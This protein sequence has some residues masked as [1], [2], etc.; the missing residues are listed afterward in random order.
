[1]AWKEPV[2]DE[3]DDI[4]QLSGNSQNEGK[5]KAKNEKTKHKELYGYIDQENGENKGPC[6]SIDKREVRQNIKKLCLGY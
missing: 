3:S 4:L 2:D 1:M 6:V 5:K